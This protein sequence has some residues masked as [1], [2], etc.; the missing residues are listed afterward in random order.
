[1]TEERNTN[2]TQGAAMPQSQG[3]MKPTHSNCKKYQFY[4][5]MIAMNDG[6]SADGIITDVQ[7]DGI[8]MLTSE[9]VEVDEN[10]NPVDEQRQY[11]YG[12]RRARR[13]RRSFFP[14]AALTAL[15]LFPY[16]TPYPYY[17]SP[18]PYYGYPYYY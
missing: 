16:L 12:R 3:Y 4:H 6:S 18:Y 8:T 13:F 14:L 2:Q 9:D 17:Y 11:G 1:M 10:G 5:V 15:A 7:E